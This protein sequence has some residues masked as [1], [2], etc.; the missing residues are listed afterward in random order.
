MVNWPRL[1][2]RVPK[3]VMAAPA[4]ITGQDL[5]VYKVL[6]QVVHGDFEAWTAMQDLFTYYP[7]PRKIPTECASRIRQYIQQAT[8]NTDCLSSP[9]L[10]DNIQSFY[11]YFHTS[12]QEK[13]KMVT[14]TAEQRE[15]QKTILQ[16][17]R[18]SQYID[19]F[20]LLAEYCRRSNAPCRVL[21]ALQRQNSQVLADGCLFSIQYEPLA[22]CKYK[23]NNG[24]ISATDQWT[25]VM[26]RDGVATPV[27]PDGVSAAGDALFLAKA[28]ESSI[29]QVQVWVDNHFISPSLFWKFWNH[30]SNNKPVD[31]YIIQSLVVFVRRV[32]A[33][34][35]EDADPV[36]FLQMLWRSTN[37]H[38]ITTSAVSS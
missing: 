23:S 19:C 13:P 15:W 32:Y 4:P 27:L 20:R 28:N 34:V 3:S 5:R 22:I 36:C 26:L 16:C 2:L 37:N 12:A 18:S 6:P 1:S 14:F 11:D 29:P 7:S 10:M 24:I 25:V 30:L 21:Q 33:P 9:Q 35:V 38:A 8:G 17:L 31:S